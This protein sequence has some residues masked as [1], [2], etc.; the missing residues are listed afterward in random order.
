MPNALVV[1][2]CIG[3]IVDAVAIFFH[4]LEQGLSAV[5]EFRVG[6]YNFTMLK[7]NQI[8]VS[9]IALGAAV[10][11]LAGCGQ[12]GSLYLPER[13]APKPASTAPTPLPA[14]APTTP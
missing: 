14:T 13:S 5:Q 8:L 1:Q 12:T 10:L 11:N 2:V 7:A 6:H 3:F 4:R 9:V